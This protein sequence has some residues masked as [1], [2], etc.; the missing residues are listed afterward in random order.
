MPNENDK[1]INDAGNIVQLHPSIE[2][3]APHLFHYDCISGYFKFLKNNGIKIG[4]RYSFHN[5]SK[6]SLNK[7]SIFVF[8]SSHVIEYII[9]FNNHFLGD[10]FDSCK[11]SNTYV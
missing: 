6:I 3:Q 5:E 9:L 4:K 11:Y 1:N 8:V 10:N 2:P 7:L